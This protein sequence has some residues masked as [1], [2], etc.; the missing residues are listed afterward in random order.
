MQKEFDRFLNAFQSAWHADR[1]NDVLDLWD[2][3]EAEPWHF[4]EE[5][6]QALVGR[7]AIAD[8][9]AMA[10]KVITAFEVVIDDPHIK[11][12]ADRCYTFRFDMRWQATMGGESLYSKPIGAKVR[13]SGV[14][15]ETNDGLKLAHYMEAGPAALPYMLAQYEQ[16]AADA[17]GSAD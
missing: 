7:E 15:R 8:Y 11:P 5:L 2:P 1:F 4:P 17:F 10:A 12:L 6:S 9:L 3:N 16:F 13:V 14:L